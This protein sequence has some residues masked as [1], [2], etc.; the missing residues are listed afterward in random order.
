MN[1]EFKVGDVVRRT[2]DH[3]SSILYNIIIKGDV[4]VITNLTTDTFCE[5]QVK[6]FKG[7]TC[8]C[9]ISNLELVKSDEQTVKIDGHS[10]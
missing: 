5:I 2:A 8:N 4:G 9:D 10:P 6:F 3:G 1:N 7:I